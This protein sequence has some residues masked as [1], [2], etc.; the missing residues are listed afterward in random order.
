MENYIVFN[1]AF[2]L[3]VRKPFNDSDSEPFNEIFKILKA[4]N[5]KIQRVLAKNFIDY[6]FK[7]ADIL[8]PLQK[9]KPDKIIKK[10]KK[11]FPNQSNMITLE[12]IELIRKRNEFYS[13]LNKK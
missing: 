6:L 1:S 7:F 11:E 9:E 12:I 13:K 4:G 2:K 8:K 3:S 5:F 10:L